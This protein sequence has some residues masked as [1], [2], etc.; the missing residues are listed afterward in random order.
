MKL[1]VLLSFG[2]VVLLAF[3]GYNFSLYKVNQLRCRLNLEHGQVLSD[4]HDLLDKKKQNPERDYSDELS[5]L[6]E[7]SCK[8][9]KAQKALYYYSYSAKELFEFLFKY[10]GNYGENFGT[11][12]GI[13]FE[14]S[15]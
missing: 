8:I 2:F 5:R 6:Y 4:L 1:L 10:Q 9:M 7:K 12:Y 13:S 14:D 3:T 11:D 15:E